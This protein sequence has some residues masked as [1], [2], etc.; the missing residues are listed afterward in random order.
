M[1]EPPYRDIALRYCVDDLPGASQPGAG[2]QGILEHLR[3]G[4]PL[5]PL[6][7][8]FLQQKGTNRSPTSPPIEYQRIPAPKQLRTHGSIPKGLR[9][10]SRRRLLRDV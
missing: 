2:L 5:T 4:R 7:L 10:A 8:T 6:A 9:V 1:T 3:L